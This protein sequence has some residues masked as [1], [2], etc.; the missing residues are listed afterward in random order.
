M[1]IIEDIVAQAIRAGGEAIVVE[2]DDDCDEVVPVA[3]TIGTSIGLRLKSSS[4]EAMALRQACM[5]S[6][7]RDGSSLLKAASRNCDVSTKAL[8]RMRFVSNGNRQ[9]VFQSLAATRTG[10]ADFAHFKV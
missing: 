7:R 8:V 10:S 2:H 9:S 5:R 6:R 4:A 1:N 3:G